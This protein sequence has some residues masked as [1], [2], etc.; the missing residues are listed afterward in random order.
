VELRV[1]D[2]PVV[3]DDHATIQEAVD[4]AADGEAVWIRPGRWDGPVETSGRE[5]TLAGLGD[6]AGEVIVDAHSAGS[7]VTH[8]G[9]GSLLLAHLTLTAG[10]AITGGALHVDGLDGVELHDVILARNFADDGGGLWALDTPLVVSDTVV[11]DNHASMGGGGMWITGNGIDALASLRRT[12]FHANTAGATGGALHVAGLPTPTSD[13]D[14]VL[15]AVAC[16]ANE[17]AVGACWWH[18]GDESHLVAR[19]LWLAGNVGASVGEASDGVDVILSPAIERND[20]PVIFAQGAVPR[21]LQVFDGFLWA[22]AVDEPADPFVD[23]EIPATNWAVD[24]PLSAFVDDGIPD[25]PFGLR[26]GSSAFDAGFVDDHDADGSRADAGAC[27]GPAAPPSC[28]RWLHDGDADGLSDGWELAFGL[29]PAVPDASADADGDG[30]THLSEHA[31]GTRPD[32]ADSDLDGVDDATE[33]GGAGDPRDDH[34]HRPVAAIV[35]GDVIGSVGAPVALDASPSF[36]PD[37]DPVIVWTWTFL[38]TA[39]GSALTDADITGGA[40]ASFVPDVPGTWQ[41]ALTVTAGGAT[42]RELVFHVTALP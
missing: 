13:S 35:N 28:L 31:A 12:T 22:N 6:A 33:I 37:G 25:D 30:V 18:T 40:A 14:V 2:G 32:R 11:T 34:H 23:P 19:N 17:A 10:R 41:L 38:S 20:A 7:V 15:E 24:D 1:L 42:S 29:D 16:V 21:V 8:E 39:P 26:L 27:G 36:D 4:A 5:L 3:P 9:G